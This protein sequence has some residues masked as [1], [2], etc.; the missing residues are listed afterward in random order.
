MKEKDFWAAID[1]LEGCVD[2]ASVHEL[3]ELLLGE[4]DEDVASFQRHL[5]RILSE[6]RR[7]AEEAGISLGQAEACAVVAA[8]KKVY[9]RILKEPAKFRECEWDCEEALLLE[10]AAPEVQGFLERLPAPPVTSG[11]LDVRFGSDFTIPP[12]YE[13]S[14]EQ[15]VN[16]IDE[17]SEWSRWWAETQSPGLFVVLEVMKSPELQ[18]PPRLRRR[19][20][21]VEFSI[22]VDPHPVRQLRLPGKAKKADEVARHD[23]AVCLRK[24]AEE[25]SLSAPPPLPGRAEERERPPQQ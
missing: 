9:K 5:E 20:D 15:L 10:R 22:N 21:I 14:V 2:E 7:R 16:L 17:S 3:Q 4:D 1:E 6:L 13:K 23:L 24:V 18:E 25:L 11:W 19:H 8:G 12:I